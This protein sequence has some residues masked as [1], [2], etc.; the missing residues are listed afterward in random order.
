VIH[1]DQDAN[2]ETT[3][4]FD[5]RD[6]GLLLADGVFDTAMVI[7]G[8]MVFRDR[9][10]A[11]LLNDA[12]AFGIDVDPARIDAAID[13]VIAG[14]AFGSVRVTVTR[15]AG[16]RGL[17]PVG[18]GRATVLAS[19]AP[20][21]PT[22]AFAPVTVVPTAIR[23]NE[24][25][26][27]A[28]HKTLAYI[29]SV[30]AAREAAAAGADEALLLNTKGR[31]ACCAAANVFVLAGETLTT[32]PLDDGAMAG[33]TRAWVLANAH[34]AGLS[35]AETTISPGEAA[36]ADAAFLTSSLR[37]IAPAGGVAAP[38]TPLQ[39]PAVTRL[40]ELLVDDLVAEGRTPPFRAP[41]GR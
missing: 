25:S 6:R 11:R 1:L 12:K 18:V 24:T 10:V 9:H 3:R 8:A 26:P 20:G 32:P 36:R 37:L 28:R 27:A 21:D 29:D 22:R 15:G 31:L 19:A 33:V 39:P 23:R 34:R 41:T 40:M 17:A 4:P 30:M 13:G 14:L 35:A 5:L 7:G 38:G 16:A 2:A